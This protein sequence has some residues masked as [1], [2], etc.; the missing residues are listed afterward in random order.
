MSDNAITL[1][2][3]AYLLL[4]H[5]SFTMIRQ[6]GNSSGECS[7]V[8]TGLVQTAKKARPCLIAPSIMHTFLHTRR[9]CFSMGDL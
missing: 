6:W 4:G 5:N 3:K 9:P 1:S 8:P 2:F 7:D